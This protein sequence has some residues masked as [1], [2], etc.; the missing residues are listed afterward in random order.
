MCRHLS[1]HNNNG[2]V[3]ICDK[4]NAEHPECY[5][6]MKEAYER[7][8]SGRRLMPNNECTFYYNQAL[9]QCPCYEENQ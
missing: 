6:R 5:E 1:F 7:L 4:N 3:A 2:R 8:F 9:Q